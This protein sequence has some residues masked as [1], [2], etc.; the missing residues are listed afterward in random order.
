MMPRVEIKDIDGNAMT[1]K[2]Y[3]SWKAALGSRTNWERAM[4]VNTTLDNLDLSGYNFD[5]A[6]LCGT[7]FRQV[8]LRGATFRKANLRETAFEQTTMAGAR[9]DRAMMDRAVLYQCGIHSAVF[10]HCMLTRA[11]LEDLSTDGRTSWVGTY[12]SYTI[13]RDI[14]LGRTPLTGCDFC[15]AD[16]EG[17]ILVGPHVIDAGQDVR[18]YRFFAT[19]NEDGVVVVHVGCQQF[20]GVQE[21]RSYN[22]EHEYAPIYKECLA[23]VTMIAAGAK[24]RGW[25]L[26]PKQ[27]KQPRKRT[28]ADAHVWS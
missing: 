24:A 3:K 14:V 5:G 28:R 9:F 18:G 19:Q 26:E 11:T 17:A 22:Y 4:L 27:T 12:F 20:V 6:N 2:A 23:K 7:T 15:E 25:K 21:A 16:M 8:N 1:T 13:L 10:D